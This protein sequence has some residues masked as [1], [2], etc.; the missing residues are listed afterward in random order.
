LAFFWPLRSFVFASLLLKKEQDTDQKFQK[1]CHT[2]KHNKQKN[3]YTQTTRTLI[4]ISL[5]LK[6]AC[7]FVIV[8]WFKEDGGV[9]NYY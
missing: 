4:S 8:E 3:A 2:K 9:K 5:S 1:S 7:Y 6:R